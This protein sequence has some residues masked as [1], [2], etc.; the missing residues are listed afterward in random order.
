MA[1]DRRAAPPPVCQAVGSSSAS[2]SA[3]NLL[4][5][6]PLGAEPR[7]QGEARGFDGLKNSVFEAR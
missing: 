3:G 2:G 7:G 5:A 4:A 1:A 6:M